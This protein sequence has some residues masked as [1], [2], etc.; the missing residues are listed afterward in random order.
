[1]KL[2]KQLFIWIALSISTLL[3]YQNCG[4]QGEIALQVDPAQLGGEKD[5]ICQVNPNH[6]LCSG[7]APIGKVEEYRYIDVKQPQIPDLKIFL[8]L[9]NSD[10]MRVSQVNLVNN[11]EKMF[12]ANGDGLRDYNSEI[13][14]LTT[15]QLNN[16]GNKLFKTSIDSKN[17]YQKI[18]DR[19][20]SAQF[21]NNL[22]QL[23]S[24]LRPL[25]NGVTKTNGLLAGDMVGFYGK[26]LRTPSVVSP[27][28]DTFEYNFY[29]AYVANLNQPSVLSVKYQKGGSITELVDRL[30][31][32]V[33][34]LNSDNQVLSKTISIENSV[35]DNIPL[36][37]VVEK[38]SGLCALGRV[39]YD[40]KNNPS[41]SLIKK[42]ELATFILVS[43]EQEHDLAGAECVKSFRYQ[44]PLPGTLYKGIC[45]DNEANVSYEVP[46]K[47]DWKLQVKQPYIK[48]VR[49]AQEHINGEIL[50]VDGKCGI[51]FKQTHA[52][53]KVNKN[54]HKVTF[55]R[56]I[57]DGSGNTVVKSWN[58][59]LTFNRIN[60]KHTYTFDRIS[61][62]HNLKFDRTNLKHKVSSTRKL[63]TPMFNVTV[64]RRL[65]SK[66][67]KVDYIRKTILTKEGNKKV[68]VASTGLLTINIPG[69]NLATSECTPA[70]LASTA[71]IKALE[72]TLSTS[73]SYEYTISSCAIANTSKA[74]SHNQ[75]YSGNVPSVCDA[76]F[77]E[78]VFP[79]SAMQSNDVYEYD[80]LSCSQKANNVVVANITSAD[81]AGDVANV[82]CD[83]GYAANKDSSKPVVNPAIGQVLSYENVSCASSS[84][85]AI[86]QAINAIVGQCSQISDLL[87]YVKSKDGNQA[88][89]TYSNFSCVDSDTVAAGQTRIVDGVYGGASCVDSIKALEGSPANTNYANCSVNASNVTDANQTISNLSGQYSY[90]D[91]AS[92]I[93]YIRTKDGNKSAALVDYTLVGAG[94][95]NKPT[96]E[97]S[98]NL[99]I[100]SINGKK[101]TTCDANY[102]SSKDSSKP[103]L[104]AGQSLVYYDV[105][106][107]D[108]A[109][110]AYQLARGAST[111]KYDGAYGNL[112]LAYD[113]SLTSPRVCTGAEQS[114][115][116]ANESAASP[117]MVPDGNVL[118][119]VS[120]MV[121][122]ADLVSATTA[123]NNILSLVNADA[124]VKVATSSAVCDAPIA[125]HCAV[126][127]TNNAGG[128]LGCENK[129]TDFVTYVAYKAE[130]RKYVL[131][132]PIFDAVKK[133]LHWFGFEP[134]QIVKNGNTMNISLLAL[135]CDEVVGACGT[136]PANASQIVE[137]YFKMIYAGND[138]AVWSAIKKL[139]ITQNTI[140]DPTNLA[141]ACVPDAIKD[142]SG[143]SDSRKDYEICNNKSVNATTASDIAYDTVTTD[144]IVTK[145]L[146]DTV[147]CNEVCTVDKCKV[148]TGSLAAIPI[149][150][151]ENGNT[152]TLTMGEFYGNNCAVGSYT[153]STQVTKRNLSKINL[154]EAVRD[155]A[156]YNNNA[157]VCNLTC[158]DTGLCKSA[159]NLPAE[160]SSKTI[161]QYLADLNSID[162]A[163]IASCKVVRAAEVAIEDRVSKNDVENSC[164]RPAGSLLANKYIK[165]KAYISY[166][167]S[168]MPNG[169]NDVV[170]IRENSDNMPSYITSSFSSVLGDG[171]VSMA[172]FSSQVSDGQGSTVGGA[173]D[174]I[175]RSIN[176]VIKD[177]KASSGQ[178]GEALKFL[179]E[180]V[181]SQLKS[182][183]QVPDVAPSQQV[184]RVWYSSWFTKGKF[185][186]LNPT[187]FSA[188]S[189][190]I[191]ITNPEIIEKMKNEASF[192]FFVEIY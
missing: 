187:D 34:L 45:A 66:Y 24:V 81:I 135:T 123:S 175:A 179:G 3:F 165:N 153:A 14:I 32:R 41:E 75:D 126:G 55:S 82:T 118:E 181:A 140:S 70:W 92:L 162:A 172:S 159:A 122:N 121:S 186:Q 141:I 129:I 167:G 102:A 89:V 192:K 10:S 72:G 174:D 98:K 78:S 35:A 152:R 18:L 12:S 130:K 116:L 52:R 138:N 9:D 23:I 54:T 85:T 94:Y 106:C 128:F 77:V 47:R 65:V 51:R 169:R 57:V 36:S 69:F 63:T 99:V 145:N 168:S 188:S 120:C 19:L 154:G 183:F 16:I 108:N 87:A 2:K 134:I 61:E 40:A 11:I 170:L 157:D 28:Y 50:K 56:K 176:G 80:V 158:Q 105:S 191:V 38:E 137:N 39:L 88:N 184:T 53:L 147:S 182:S 160:A 171:F 15:A 48:Y 100:S 180:K 27:T 113:S 59:D 97:D 21:S 111:I 33:E 6:A 107:A 133:E 190:S 4:Q 8:I 42:G 46:D 148:K 149:T 13:F 67:Q 44:Q 31:E 178:Y 189:S 177:V 83:A 156:T 119:V 5:D 110:V 93:A 163:K 109:P 142:Y 95:L 73:E 30:K 90:T 146:N 164:V 155:L 114:T 29:P 71:Q 139:S 185:V 117:A 101:P 60:K 68:E 26:S 64:N 79:K 150:V 104:T 37:E 76:A 112:L 161:K 127:A 49:Q 96:Y 173:Y 58:H 166:Y 74:E 151:V 25:D 7:V 125:S 132:A 115:I 143:T 17:D 91:D 43:D 131:K 86:N 103:A 84:T 62:K 20:Y 136:D 22:N 144:V 1:M 124:N